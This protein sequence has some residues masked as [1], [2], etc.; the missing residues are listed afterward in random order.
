MF[1]YIVDGC[2]RL[3]ET[4][5]KID[6]CNLPIAVYHTMFSD[7]TIQEYVYVYEAIYIRL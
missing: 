5:I 4:L 6:I 3:Q 7:I 1:Q 2:F